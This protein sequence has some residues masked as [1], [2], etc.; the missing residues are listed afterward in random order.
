ME[1]RKSGL[2][3]LSLNTMTIQ[4]IAIKIDGIIKVKLSY[5]KNTLFIW[6]AITIAIQYYFIMTGV[7]IKCLKIPT[8]RGQTS[9]LFTQR[10]WGVELVAT[11]NKS[12]KWWG[13]GL[14][15]GTT[16]FQVQ[17]LNQSVTPSNLSVSHCQMFQRMTYLVPPMKQPREV[18]HLQVPA[19][20][21]KVV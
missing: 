15:P 12:R 14:E 7:N 6:S 18:K 1:E 13:R 8:G 10:S 3:S 2:L 19:F 9:W 21:R 4:Q 20:R 5:N 17:H 11:E 16:R